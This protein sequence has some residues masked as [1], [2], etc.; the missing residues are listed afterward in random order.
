M[1]APEQEQPVGRVDLKV[2]SILIPD[3]QFSAVKDR[4]RP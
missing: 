3:I 2:R 4:H 1:T